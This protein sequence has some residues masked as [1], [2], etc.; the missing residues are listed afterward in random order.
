M[1]INKWWV[2]PYYIYIWSFYTLSFYY[3]YYFISGLLNVSEF[4]G[5]RDELI[6]G[7]VKISIFVFFLLFM[8]VCDLINKNK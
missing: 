3:Y 1:R 7:P 8:Y 2:C 5:Y 4:H 6:E